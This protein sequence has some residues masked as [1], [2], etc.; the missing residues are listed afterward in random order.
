MRRVGH[1]AAELLEGDLLAGHRLDHVGTGDEHVRG[2]LHH[3]REVGDR[4]G[5]DGAAGARPHDHG[6]LRDH[7]ARADV[8]FEDEAVAGERR[9][10]LLDPRPAGVVDLHE[11]RAGGDRQVHHLAD[12]LRVDLSHGAA[13][14]REVLRRHEDLP[15]P[16]GP[17]ARDD[18]VAG[19]ALAVHP[20]VVRTMDGERVRLHEGALVHQELDPFSRGELPAL[21][22]LGGGVPASRRESCLPA[23]PQLVDPFLDGGRLRGLDVFVRGRHG[24]SLVVAARRAGR[25]RRGSAVLR[26]ASRRLSTCRAR[27]HPDRHDRV[28]A[29]AEGARGELPGWARVLVVSGGP[30]VPVVLVQA[31]VLPRGLRRLGRVEAALASG[32]ADRPLLSAGDR[33]EP[34]HRANDQPLREGSGRFVVPA[35][36]VARAR[37]VMRERGRR[38]EEHARD[39]REDRDRGSGSHQRNKSVVNVRNR[40]WEG[41]ARRLSWTVAGAS[42]RVYTTTRRLA[43]RRASR[44]RPPDPG[45][46]RRRASGGAPRDRGRSR[47]RSR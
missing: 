31:P 24:R 3:E 38:S 44:R 14:D 11:G 41:P 30:E 19:R 47:R 37:G 5:V 4:G 18:A 1:R 15:S 13:E 35:M 16:D 43:R 23:L 27:H 6:D 39:D 40:R 45:I 33:T 9:G 22:L 34:L 28:R 21:V 10:A 36:E 7:A 42:P 25:A 17:V 46:P 26:E 20:E 8:A 29:S 2:L 32:D 12:L